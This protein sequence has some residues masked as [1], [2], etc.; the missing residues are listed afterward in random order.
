MKSEWNSDNFWWFIFHYRLYVN[1]CNEMDIFIAVKWIKGQ[2]SFI[3]SYGPI[4]RSN[5]P[6]RWGKIVKST[7]GTTKTRVLY[8]EHEQ[9]ATCW[10]ENEENVW[11]SSIRYFKIVVFRKRILVHEKILFANFYFFFFSSLSLCLSLSILQFIAMPRSILYRSFT[12]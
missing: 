10:K 4:S 7:P 12:T 3:F 6:K 5:L 8:S 2:L 1:G 11:T 9:L